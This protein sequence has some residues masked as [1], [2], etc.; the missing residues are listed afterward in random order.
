MAFRWRDDGGLLLIADLVALWFYMGSR[1][2][3]LRDPI[4]CFQGGGGLDPLSS[5][6]DPHMD[7]TIV[8]Q[9][10]EGWLLCFGCLLDVM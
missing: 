3:L 6:L 1:P 2:L 5:P 8:S 9:G 4:I 7:F 10:S